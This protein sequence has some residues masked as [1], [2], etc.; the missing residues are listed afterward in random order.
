LKDK[1][2]YR[3]T[4]SPSFSWKIGIYWA[5]VVEL[6]LKFGRFKRVRM[7]SVYKSRNPIGELDIV[8]AMQVAALSEIT[9]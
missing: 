8:F 1:V 2:N 6:K 4:S 9:S 3:G 7:L 5:T